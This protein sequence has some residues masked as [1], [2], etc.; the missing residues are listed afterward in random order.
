MT[1][2]ANDGDQTG[3]AGNGDSSES[4][5]DGSSEIYRR[6]RRRGETDLRT[7]RKRDRSPAR[8]DKPNP[9]EPNPQDDDTGSIYAPP[10]RRGVRRESD[11]S[12]PGVFARLTGRHR[13]DEIRTARYEPYTYESNEQNLKWTAIVMGLWCL[14]LVW[15]AFTDYGN[16][17]TYS[18]WV[19][20]GM[21]VIPPSADLASQIEPAGLYVQREGGEEFKCA[22]LGGVSATDECPDGESNPVLVTQYV[23]ETG[24]ICTN[25]G[26]YREVATAQ[27]E[28]LEDGSVTTVL[29]T[30]ESEE[31]VEIC[32]AVWT[33]FP[34]L[35]FAR[36][37]NLDCPDVN[38]VLSSIATGG[39]EYPGCERAFSY[40]EDFQSSQ[41]RSRLIWLLAI[42]VFIFVA[43]PYMS[44]LHRASRNLLPLK[45]EGQ[46]HTPEWGVLHHF[47]PLLNLFRPGGVM[48]E[49]YKGSDPNVSTDDASAW[50]RQGKVRPIVFLWWIL[51]VA[52]WFF[53]PII[54][55][56]YVN[57]QTLPELISANDLLL[58]SDV[59]LIVLGVAAVL[60][61]R[62]LHVWQE[63]RFEKVGLI[64]VTPPPPVDPLAEALQKQEAKEREKEERK[65]RRKR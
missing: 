39:I 10:R 54:V 28:V 14:V 53:N 1:G 26:E 20:E 41:D 65:N 55:P 52:A 30:V 44:L 50:K 47:I 27:E 43:F 56:R 2:P 13:L 37:T 46:K 22:Y 59:L 15:L 58:L 62:Q 19:D 29:A 12:K 4:Q 42:F 21:A 64:T 38:A 36:Q 18:D 6:P 60:M 45:S 5:P 51:W 48:M 35:E 61:L 7:S 34:L 24:A 8:V 57:A 9:D 49:L 11:D 31:P 16:S 63:M 17:Q 33:Y 25:Y 32:T 3:P 23:E 40:A